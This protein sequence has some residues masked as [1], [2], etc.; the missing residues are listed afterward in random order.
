[1]KYL[2]TV[3][4]TLVVLG[5]GTLLFPYTGFYNVAATE[6]HSGLEE[7]YLSTLSRRSIQAH[8]GGIEV[9][10]ALT[11]SGMVANGAW[12]FGQMCQ[13]CHGA[14]GIN[15]SVTGD[16]LT[17]SPPSLSETA[18]NW[19]LEELFWIVKNGIKMAGM[20]AYGPT[21][22]DE[23]LWELVGFVEQLPEISPEQYAEFTT[24]PDTTAGDNPVPPGHEGHDH[25]H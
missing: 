22:T 4:A 1:M 23:E 11:D 6:G 17:P 16:G 8:A 5:L 9:P 25:V 3:L 7:W 15:R 2:L 21:H 18:P 19:E 20:P 14:P 13:T 12:S 24:L 10:P